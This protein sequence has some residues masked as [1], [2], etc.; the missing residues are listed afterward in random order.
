L[1]CLDSTLLFWCLAPFSIRPAEVDL[2]AAALFAVIGLL[3]PAAV[4][5]LNFESNRLMGPNIAGAVS[6]L[7]PL[8]AVV[9]ALML[10]GEHLR[11]L[12]LFGIATI[13]AGVALMYSEKGRLSL[14]DDFG[15]WFCRS[16]RPPFVASFS[17]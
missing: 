10:L 8:F 2:S 3:F 7:A 9:L 5:L 16:A 17:P 15:S 14:P 13:A 4:A 11:F 12:Q 1:I 6:G